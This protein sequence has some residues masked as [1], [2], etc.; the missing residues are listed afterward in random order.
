MLR[1]DDE[2]LIGLYCA[3]CQYR[4]EGGEANFELIEGI[5]AEL[6]SRPGSP[7]AWQIWARVNRDE[8]FHRP[9]FLDADGTP[10]RIPPG[11]DR[12][13]ALFVEIEPGQQLVLDADRQSLVTYDAAGRP[14]SAYR[15]VKPA[16][17][18]RKPRT[19]TG[20]A[21]FVVGTTQGGLIA[22]EQFEGKPQ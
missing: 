22:V 9:A 14:L 21:K 16:P 18:A 10:A 17:P 7:F 1:R 5:C 15:A 13:E 19:W 11:V 20:P 12:D 8:Q 6:L 4:D 2:L 3:L